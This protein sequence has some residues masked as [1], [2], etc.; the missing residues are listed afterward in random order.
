MNELALRAWLEQHGVLLTIVWDAQDRQRFLIG[1]GLTLLLAVL[2]ILLSLVI[3]ILGGVGKAFGNRPLRGLIDAYVELFRNTPLLVQ[4]FFF[5]FGV[6][7]L[8]PLAHDASGSPV[9]VL[10]NIGWAIIVI[11][12]NSGAA[13]LE[14]LRA[15]LQAVP[16]ATREAAEALGLR[17]FR[18]LRRVLLPLALRTALPALGN[19]VI[20]TIKA[21]SVA[22]AIAVPELL[23]AA[24]R[25]SSD[26]FNVVEMM[27]VLL[28]CWL[29]VIGLAAWGLRHLERRLR[30]PGLGHGS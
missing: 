1:I 20:Q 10:N 28:L 19:T 5:Y 30:L 23:Y 26:H 14:A 24:N 11:G 12:L 17:G 18:L 25:I 13:H 15:G 21:T 4:L 16:V 6:G 27:Q 22:Y 7:S 9:R 29:T 8:L 2:S 3:G